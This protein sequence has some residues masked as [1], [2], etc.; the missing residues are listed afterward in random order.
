MIEQ[1]LWELHRPLNTCDPPVKFAVN[2]IGAASKEQT[3][4]RSNNQV[5]AVV[6]PRDFVT[7]CV[8]QG[9]KQQAKHPAV[10][11]HAALPDAEDR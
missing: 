3:N 10:T 6:H 2:E 11:G 5:V 1:F 8:V 9:E 4:R 7:L